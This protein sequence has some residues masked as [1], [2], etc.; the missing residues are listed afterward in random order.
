MSLPSTAPVSVASAA[1]DAKLSPGNR[2]YRT[3]WRWHFYAGLFVV[4]FMLILGMT[5]IVYLFKPQLDSAMYHNMMFV[6]PSGTM[7][8]YTEQVERAQAAHP[9]ATVSKFM[10]NPAGDRSAQVTLATTEGRELAVF[11]DPYTGTVLGDRDEE[12]N[13][14]AIARKIHSEL[15]IGDWGDYLIELAACWAI[16]L[17]ISGMYLWMPRQQR[18]LMGTFIP[19]LWSKNKRT[20]WRD[21]HAVPGFY[22]VLLVGFLLV[23]GLPWTGF[24][25]NTFAQVWG[26][27]PAQMW[28]NVPESTVVTGSLNQRGNLFVP[29]AAEQMPMPVS[30]LPDNAQ[31]LPESAVLVADTVL[32]A[33]IEE[34]AVGVP[35]VFDKVVALA[36]AE[37]APSGFSIAFPDGETGVYTASAFPDDPRQEVT[38]H[39][40]QYSGELLASVGWKDYGIVPKAVELGVSVHMG[41]YF[42]LANQLLMLVAALITILLAV[43]GTVMWWQRRPQGVGLIGAP[44]M[45]PYMQHW[46]IPLII[47]AVLGFVMPFVGFSLIIVLSFDYFVF[48]RVP[49]L[50]RLFG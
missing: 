29:W 30:L 45:P 28:D 10:P 39:M 34:A 48:S 17:L 3:I 24:W 36:I 16:V 6:Q 47:V 38:M 46:K 50:R 26:R 4:P 2:F 49:L 13:L 43:T 22:G 40:D 42:G 14:Q 11:V 1:V 25:G 20:F 33:D 27:F 23:T 35:P 12:R 7:L 32:V 41:K 37:G 9:G 44:A 8:P 15:L 19:R 21:L 5:G 31:M 18:S